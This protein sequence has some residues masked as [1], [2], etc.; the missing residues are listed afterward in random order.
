MSTESFTH[1]GDY[2]K[3][4]DSQSY[5]FSPDYKTSAKSTRPNA[6]T[7]L[8]LYPVVFHVWTLLNR[9]E[10]EAG[11]RIKELTKEQSWTGG[12]RTRSD[13]KL[14]FLLLND[15]IKMKDYLDWHIDWAWQCL[16]NTMS[17]PNRLR[18][19]MRLFAYSDKLAKPERLRKRLHLATMKLLVDNFQEIGQMLPLFSESLQ[20]A[21]I[22]SA[23]LPLETK[24]A[25]KYSHPEWMVRRWLRRY[26]PE[27][28][29]RIL[30]GNNERDLIV[31]RANLIDVSLLQYKLEQAGVLVKPANYHPLCLRILNL[32]GH[33]L[34]SLPSFIDGEFQIQSEMAAFPVDILAPYDGE[35]ILDMCCL[36]GTKTTQIAAGITRGIIDCVDVDP[37]E[38]VRFQS[39]ENNLRRLKLWENIE[40][41]I[42]ITFFSVDGLEFDS[43]NRYDKILIDAPCSGLGILSRHADARWHRSEEQIAELSILQAGLLDHCSY[44]LKPKGKIVYS[45]CT[46]EPEENEL[47][48]ERFLRQHPEFVVEDLRSYGIPNELLSNRGTYY[49]PKKWDVP[50]DRPIQGGF[51]ASLIRTG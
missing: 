38:G 14:A 13:I 41:P 27:A 16:P 24:L 39:M 26:A 34:E 40:R 25:K 44:L 15:T 31:M 48:V 9:L 12:L 17:M 10:G 33:R 36:P 32:R 20:K 2:Y 42:Q 30:R 7:R 46:T 18:N 47:Q 3:R 45:T 19:L 4:K 5:R 35:C 37:V 23:R 6:S 11:L 1:Q 8:A 29:E 43:N 50:V 22:D 51:A 28:V 21:D 49:Y